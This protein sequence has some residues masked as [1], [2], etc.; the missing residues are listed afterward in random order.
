VCVCERERES[1]CVL[2]YVLVPVSDN[3]VLYHNLQTQEQYFKICRSLQLGL[4]LTL[5]RKVTG[6]N[7]ILQ[8]QKKYI[9]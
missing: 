4:D 5:L 9:H 3:T 8:L 7:K 2:V 6:H 1:V